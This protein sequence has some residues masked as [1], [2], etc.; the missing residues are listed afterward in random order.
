MQQLVRT[1]QALDEVGTRT[2]AR[3]DEFT[4]Q[5]GRH[6]ERAIV[7]LLVIRLALCIAA[8]LD[9]ISEDRRPTVLGTQGGVRAQIADRSIAD[10][11]AAV[12]RRL[13][14]EL[15]RHAQARRH[16][17]RRQGSFAG[18]QHPIENRP[19]LQIGTRTELG[20][21]DLKFLSHSPKELETRARA[22]TASRTAGNFSVQC[23]RQ[24]RH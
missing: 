4:V 18:I 17:L 19:S 5:I 9:E 21:I 3:Q 1:N 24:I 22:S 16:P 2:R 15:E 10:D 20:K 23:F 14:L 11:E 7:L 13:A 6:R 12:G 8:R